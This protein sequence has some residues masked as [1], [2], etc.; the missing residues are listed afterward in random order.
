MPIKKTLDQIERQIQS[1]IESG[2]DRLTS[3][4]GISD[5]LVHNLV[6]AMDSNVREEGDR[7]EAPNHYTI[8]LPPEAARE[9]RENP[10]AVDAVASALEKAGNDAGVE[11]PTAPT[12]T[13]IEDHEL[14]SG[15]IKISARFSYGTPGST[16]SMTEDLEGKPEIIP[17][18]A[19][20]IISGSQVFQLAQAVINIGRRV[21]NNLVIDDPSVSR[22]HAQLRAIDGN[23]VLFDLGSTGGSFV[24]SQRVN[25]CVLYPGD[26]IS[27][28]GVQLVYGQ[29]SPRP[30]S[31]TPGYTK[32]IPVD[33]KKTITIKQSRSK[34]D[35][36]E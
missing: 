5:L 13:F 12:I 20:L 1:L 31:E 34:K 30:L 26:V 2:A 23:F 24:N 27:L 3:T 19:F 16:K 6:I 11:F 10:K 17:P 35:Q 29:D 14:A 33:Q 36:N 8:M 18:N 21:D 15:E 25:S 9:F 22:L 4:A 7:L 28:A 32:P